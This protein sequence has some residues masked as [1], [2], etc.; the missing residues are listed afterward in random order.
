MAK[1]YEHQPDGSYRY[2]GNYEV[3]G[4]SVEDAIDAILGCRG[5]W[6]YADQ[7]RFNSD[8]HGYGRN[9]VLVEID[10]GDGDYTPYMIVGGD[11]AR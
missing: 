5:D 2:N 11:R 9:A 7:Y 10:N 3:N 1:V 4:L 6:E 8:I